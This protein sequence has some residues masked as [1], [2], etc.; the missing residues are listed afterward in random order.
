MAR[1]RGLNTSQV[2]SGTSGN[3]TIYGNGGDDGISGGAGHDVIYG[4]SGNDS[5]NGGAGWDE[6]TGGI[7]RDTFIFARGESGP[8]YATADVIT[9]FVS[10][11]DDILFLGNSPAGNSSNYREFFLGDGFGHGNAQQDYNEALNEARQ[12]IGGNVRYAFYTNG[13]DGYLFADLDGNGTV[14]TSVELRGL[15]STGDFSSSDIH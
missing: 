2:M 5:I 11:N 15:D 3:D 4:G 13:Q 14:D 10:V 12:D 6:L 8:T 9:D 1:I 7:G